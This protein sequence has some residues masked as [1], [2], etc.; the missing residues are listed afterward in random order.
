MYDQSQRD[1]LMPG[2]NCEIEVALTKSMPIL[3][4]IQFTLRNSKNTIAFGK[5]T[6]VKKPLPIF[7][8]KDLSKADEMIEK[9]MVMV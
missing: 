1:L 9:D 3:P 7:N 6:E 4:G 5:V 8:M 2:D